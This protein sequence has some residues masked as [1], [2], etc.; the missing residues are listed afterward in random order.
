VL[1]DAVNVTAR[2]A[3]EAGPGE[4]LVSEATAATIGVT[5]AALESRRLDIRGRSAPIGVLVLRV[6]SADSGR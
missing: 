5:D 3:S 2:L 1:A 6:A 4:L